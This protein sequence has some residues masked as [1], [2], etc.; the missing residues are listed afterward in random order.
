M[1]KL[2]ARESHILDLMKHGYDNI[3]IANMV[4]VS[5]HTVKA[6][7]TSIIRKF[8]ANNRTHVIH[9]AHKHGLI[10]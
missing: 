10:E 6:H 2:T 4:F 8:Q 7:V 9:L 1:E 5:R 3:E